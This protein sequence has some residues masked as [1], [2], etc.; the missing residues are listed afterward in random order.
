MNPSE[1]VDPRFVSDPAGDGLPETADD[2]AHADLERD[3]VRVTDGLDPAPLPPDRDDGPMALDDYGTTAGEHVR[4][5]PL[6]A[7]L[8]RESP[9]LSAAAVRID[10]NPA[11]T[12]DLDPRASDQIEFDTESLGPLPALDEDDEAVPLDRVGDEPP[13][14]AKD[15]YA[16]PELDAVAPRLG[17]HV[18]IYD[19]PVP[20]IPGTSTIGR[21]ARPDGD[22]YSSAEADEVA[23]DAGS[24]GGAFSAEE[25]AMHEVPPH[26]LDA[27]AGES[28]PYVTGENQA[29]VGSPTNPASQ[30]E[31]ETEPQPAEAEPQPAEAKPQPEVKPEPE[32]KPAHEAEPEP[33]PRTQLEA[34]FDEEAV[35]K[36][37]IR[38]GAEQDW[39]PA[40]LALAEGRDPTPENIARAEREMRRLGPAA[41]ERTVP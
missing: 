37:V 12:E 1:E 23:F 21:L 7:R 13:V 30:A 17:D 20:G 41:V 24:T 19:R 29:P 31:R 5:E 38:T 34:P 36:L 28:E 2:D 25:A 10:P 22:G 16:D 27:Q 3:R 39:D 26:L 15:A 11:F 14:R 6:D 35:R 40:D 32:A 4:N 33:E 8:A 18:S 9:D